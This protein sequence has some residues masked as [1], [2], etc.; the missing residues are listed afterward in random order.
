[1][2]ARPSRSAGTRATVILLAA[3]SVVVAALSALLAQSGAINRTPTAVGLLGSASRDSST[4]TMAV[5]RPD[6]SF[7]DQGRTGPVQATA[8]RMQWDAQS[9]LLAVLAGTGLALVMAGRAAPAGVRSR[10]CRSGDRSARHNRGPPG[11]AVC[12]A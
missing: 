12:F 9:H 2:P 3:V 6:G 11:R 10:Q 1:M 8:P 7:A 5:R 4:A